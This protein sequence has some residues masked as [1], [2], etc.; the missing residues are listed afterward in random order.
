MPTVSV[1]VPTRNRR[2][3]LTRLL[4]KLAEQPDDSGP[5]EV[6]VVDDGSTD[7]TVAS[8]SHTRWPVPVR[9]VQQ[10][11]S[12][13]A[14]A[15]NSGARIATGDVLL[16]LD[17]D[18][19]PE[20]GLIAAHASAHEREDD[21]VGLGDLPARIT[22]RSYFGLMLRSWW[23][24]MQGA[25]RTPGHR[26]CFN[27]LLSGHFSIARAQFERLGGFNERL[28]CREDYEL[29][30]RVIQAGLQMRFLPEAIAGHHDSSDLTKALRRKFDEG[31]ADLQ[32]LHCHPTLGRSLP[33]SVWP[34]DSRLQRLTVWLLWTSPSAGRVLMR[35]LLAV[36]PAL[37]HMNRR[38]RWRS[39]LNAL[40]SYWY[41]R[42]VAAGISSYSSLE[43]QLRAPSR[44]MQQPLTIDLSLGLDAA[45]A[46]LEAER[47]RAVRLMLDTA[48]IGD[49]SA[50]P[51]EEAF[52]ASHLRPLLATML[53]EK[54][55]LALAAAGRV[56]SELLP[57]A[58]ALV[59]EGY[60][61]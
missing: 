12:G 10:D 51:G 21:I 38:R 54:Y 4:Q 8:I 14:V 28:R 37:E 33:L 39:V 36:L 58:P 59:A 22:D 13:A 56:P 53:R 52:R 23:A 43:A 6:I 7:D 50:R 24:E 9:V 19:E 48:A 18:V 46:Q 47:P 61:K 41:W 44:A 34:E 60:R 17:D 15:R 2:S 42:G 49:V 25:L 3:S 1:I 20:P 5:C 57:V 55:L 35:A 29:G 45:E 40:L 30:Y 31:T 11:G 26:H 32:I 16:F 27:D